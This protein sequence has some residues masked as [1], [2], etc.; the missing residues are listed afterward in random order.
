MQQVALLNDV[1]TVELQKFPLED[2]EYV[3][4]RV[5]E[6]LLYNSTQ[7]TGAL[8]KALKKHGLA[9]SLAVSDKSHIERGVEASTYRAM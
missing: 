1:Q 8:T 4:Q 9:P 3:L 7:S 2:G 6:Y 5:A